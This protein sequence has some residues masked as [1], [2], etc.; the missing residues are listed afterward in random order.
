MI[1][2]WKENQK[3]QK[4]NVFRRRKYIYSP[5]NETHRKADKQEQNETEFVLLWIQPEG[6]VFPH[7]HNFH[8]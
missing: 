7:F 3:Q 6:G 1:T 4:T 2:F 8:S 5:S